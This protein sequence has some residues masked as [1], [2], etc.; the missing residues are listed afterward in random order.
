MTLLDAYAL[1]ALIADEPAAEDVEMILRG[2]DARVVISNLAEAVDVSRRAL[3]FPA[4]TVR[5]ALEPLLMTGALEPAVST[6]DH[7]WL[8]AEL[9]GQHYDRKSCALSMADCFLLAH[10]LT[11]SDSIATADPAVVVVARSA[12]VEVRALPDSTGARP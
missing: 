8:A 4:A 12:G 2:G 3:G 11:D 1:V 6:E 5:T 9:R 7:A 10:G